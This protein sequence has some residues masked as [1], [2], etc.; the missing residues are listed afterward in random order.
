MSDETP[1]LLEMPRIGSIDIGH[2]A[3]AEGLNLPFSIR[4]AYWTFNTPPE[5]LRGHHAHK[6]LRQVIFAVSGSIRIEL[7]NRRGDKRT[8]EL[9]EPW[10]GLY[11]PP[12]YWR[13]I[14]LSHDAVLLCLASD[15]FVESDYIR[16]YAQFR[17]E[18]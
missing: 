18:E 14:H 11:V 15:E 12:M 9:T 7:E 1:Y 3:V 8:F 5:V 6:A 16:D 13:T 4:R 17:N 2:I 10:R